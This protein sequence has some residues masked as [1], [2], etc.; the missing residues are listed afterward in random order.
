MD[1]GNTESYETTPQRLTAAIL[2]MLKTRRKA[3]KKTEQHTT[4]DHHMSPEPD[5]SP[6]KW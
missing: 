6:R 3:Q 4:S 1:N 5:E 2:N